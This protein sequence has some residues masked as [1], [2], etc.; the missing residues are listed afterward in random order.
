MKKYQKPSSMILTGASILVLAS[1]LPQ[2][3]ATLS[4]NDLRNIESQ[5]Q[6]YSKAFHQY[7]NRSLNAVVSSAAWSSGSLADGAIDLTSAP[8]GINMGNAEAYLESAHCTDGGDSFHLTWFDSADAG[9]NVSLKGLGR[10][11]IG[12]ANTRIKGMISHANFG[13]YDGTNV[14][15]GDGTSFALSGNCATLTLPVGT[16]V[17]AISMPAPQNIMVAEETRTILRAAA[18]PAGEQGG[19]TQSVNA[20]FFAEPFDG[21]NT[22]KVGADNYINEQDVVNNHATWNEI[23]R[24][25]FTSVVAQN[26]ESTDQNVDIIDL[27][28][29]ITTGDMSAALSGLEDVTCRIV[30]KSKND[31]HSQ[32]DPGNPDYGEV[33]PDEVVNTCGD[34]V[35]LDTLDDTNVIEKTLLGS[36]VTLQTL[37]C[38]AA[39]TTAMVNVSQSRFNGLPPQTNGQTV[40]LNKSG[41]IG[42]LEV[43]K[44]VKR[45]GVTTDLGAGATTY[46]LSSTEFEGV[47][48]SCAGN[49]ETSL[50]CAQ[51]KPSASATVVSGT[52]PLYRQTY[53]QNGWS[54]SEQMIPNTASYGLW[55]QVS[56]NC[57]Y[58]RVKTIPVPCPP[59]QTGNRTQQQESTADITSGWSAWTNVG[60]VSGSCST[61]SSGGSGVS[62]Q[63]ADGNYY[64]SEDKADTIG[65]GYTGV[66]GDAS[67]IS[68]GSGGSSS[69]GC[70]I[71]GTMVKMADGTEKAI[72]Q[73]GLG[74]EVFMGGRVMATGAF[75]VTEI[76]DYMGVT[77]SGSHAVY[78]DG[79]WVRV[80]DAKQATL[81]TDDIEVAVYVHVNEHHRI[82]INDI[83]FADYQEVGLELSPYWDDMN[84]QN[85][86][87]MNT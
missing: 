29:L 65:G 3:E 74:D 62:W 51:L 20:Q 57:N 7:A 75:L 24:D 82:I 42:N 70:F 21:T 11:H 73:I 77:V 53:N 54:D 49:Y 61:S 66:Q 4:D 55:S 28:G 38:P 31:S 44:I 63:G 2:D 22:V 37:S 67:Q 50:S 17:S 19:I 83:V 79:V 18:C 9:G 48:L 80:R 69:S 87:I 6:L 5:V 78:E 15:M 59:G 26:L 30:H 52:S 14:Q 27:S 8:F 32:Y 10:S 16:A 39:A 33:A 76:Y 12:Q 35:S 13:V 47:G 45:W 1:C 36:D 71:A 72:E 43:N 85:I 23:S 68:G 25:C 81:L 41:V 46:E 56:G 64:G 58:K 40:T 34:E 60:A 84:D 86:K